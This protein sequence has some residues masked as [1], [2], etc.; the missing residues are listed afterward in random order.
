[1]QQNP[2]PVPPIRTKSPLHSLST[3]DLL[4]S[5][6]PE[7]GH[8][9]N[10][11]KLISESRGNSN[12]SDSLVREC[13]NGVSTDE[14]ILSSTMDQEPW[15]QIPQINTNSWRKLEILGSGSFGTVYEAMSE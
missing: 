13:K 14:N 2:L 4:A 1:M 10:D 11:Q 8:L 12:A 15:N 3:H 7:T 5:F 9:G 6:A